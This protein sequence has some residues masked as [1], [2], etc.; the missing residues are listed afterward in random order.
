MNLQDETRTDG[1]RQ[2]ALHAMPGLTDQHCAT[3]A[4]AAAWRASAGLQGKLG[5]HSAEGTPGAMDRP[6]TWS[7]G[8][9]WGAA[10]RAAR[11]PQPAGM[12]RAAR[13]GA[14]FVVSSQTLPDIVRLSNRGVSLRRG[15]CEGRRLPN[16]QA[17]VCARMAGLV[18]PSHQLCGGGF[19]V[20]VG[21]IC[22]RAWLG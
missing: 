9:A 16:R 6:S 4:Q 22:M 11:C 20:A 3:N 2:G 8:S 15:V 12:R 21:L 18:S 14:C 7:A 5:T 19:L 13:V 17:Q 1:S 10:A